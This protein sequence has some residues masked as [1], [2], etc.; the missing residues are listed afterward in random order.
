[1][2]WGTWDIPVGLVGLAEDLQETGALLEQHLEAG[3]GYSSPNPTQLDSYPIQL[4]PGVL[5]HLC[6]GRIWA[7][8]LCQVEQR[9]C[10][11]H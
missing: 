4:S 8:M 6:R 1:M 11:P 10:N 7:G 5:I 2:P 9:A 3:G